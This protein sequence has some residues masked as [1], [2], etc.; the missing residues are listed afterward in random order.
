MIRAA[1][2]QFD[3]GLTQVGRHPPKRIAERIGGFGPAARAPGVIADQFI[4][5]SEEFGGG[6]AEVG[7]DQRSNRLVQRRDLESKTLR[8][9]P[10]PFIRLKKPS[11][12]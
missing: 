1:E 4:E 9:G 3:S 7:P 6:P 5:L 2:L 8:V 10:A 11:W 12:Y